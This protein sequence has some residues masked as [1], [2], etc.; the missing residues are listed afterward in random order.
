MIL[1]VV[2]TTVLLSVLVHGLTAVPGSRW[3]AARAEGADPE[4]AEH[5]PIEEMP[6]RLPYETERTSDH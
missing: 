1:S 2:M 5:E 3:Y 4:A 6:V